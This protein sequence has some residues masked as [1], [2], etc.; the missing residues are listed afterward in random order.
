MGWRM[1]NVGCGT[2]DEGCKMLDN[3]LLSDAS[4]KV[5]YRNVHRNL[6]KREI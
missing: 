6:N 5:I 4:S 2:R 3:G 1:M